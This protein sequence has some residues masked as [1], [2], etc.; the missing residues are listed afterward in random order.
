MIKKIF[1]PVF[2]LFF[3]VFFA[4]TEKYKASDYS[5]PNNVKTY[6]TFVYK[7]DVELGKYFVIEKHIRIFEKGLLKYD[8]VLDNYGSVTK[9]GE[10]SLKELTLLYEQ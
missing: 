3:A 2:V 4:Q 1:V 9:V 6:N 10:K 8:Y 5:L 7:Y